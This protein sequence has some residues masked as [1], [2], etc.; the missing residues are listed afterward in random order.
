MNFHILTYGCQMNYADSARI[1]TI[2]KNIWFKQV[3]TIEQS[4]IVIF[5]TCSVRQK[6]EDKIT[7][8][9]KEIPKD[10]KIWITWCMIQHN[11]SKKRVEDRKENSIKMKMKKWNFIWNLS[12]VEYED[13]P[14]I[15]ND[16]FQPLWS[17][18][19]NKFSNLE[20]L[21]R[22]DDVHLLPKII[23]YLGYNIKEE[24]IS[25][26]SSYV[27]LLPNVAN[28]TED[29]KLKTA[30]VPISTWCN[31]FCSYCIVPF[32]RW[33]EKNREVKDIIKEVEYWTDKGKEEIV[34]IWQIVNKHP[35]FYEILKEVLKNKKVKWLRYTSPYPTYY[36]DEI[37]K[38][39]EEEERL[40]PHI[41]I[42]VQSGSNKILKL[43]NRWYS[44]EQFKEFIDK[45][46]SLKR[47]ISITTDIIV[48]FTDETEDDFKQSVELAQYAKFDMIYVGIYSPRPNT[49]AY[50]NLKDNIPRQTKKERWSKLNDVLYDIS[51]EN[52]KKDIWKTKKAMIVW[53][54]ENTYYGYTEDMKNIELDNFDED[55]IWD[56]VDI[57]ITWS[58]P[59][60]LFGEYH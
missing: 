56:I 15:T 31:Q 22:I 37:F 51:L 1:A 58:I 14:Y 2:L 42:P 21:F 13:I 24:E 5:D 23:K 38:L 9:L 40:C 16:V 32:A 52:N 27:D 50:K 36:S 46:R 4:D 3:K 59:L 8:K 28:Q 43:M 29:E 10:K 60:K 53:K 48:W 41:H 25:K 12:D 35:K 54:K 34:L 26:I 18:L 57:K 49:R 6:S 45:I 39:H 7:W 20:L 55:K 19:K 30:Y 44:I 17:T 47:P 33:F 11:M